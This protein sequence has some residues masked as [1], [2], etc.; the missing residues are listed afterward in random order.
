MVNLSNEYIIALVILIGIVINYIFNKFSKKKLP[1][2]KEKPIIKFEEM[3]NIDSN[4]Y[5]INV[6]FSFDIVNNKKEISKITITN[7]YIKDNN[8]YKVCERDTLKPISP[9]HMNSDNIRIDD[10][11]SKKF[12]Q[13]ICRTPFDVLFDL[14]KNPFLG[15][16]NKDDINNDIVIRTLFNKL[17]RF[18]MP[19]T[20]R[21][22]D[23]ILEKYRNNTISQKSTSNGLIKILNNNLRDCNIRKDGENHFYIHCKNTIDIKMLNCLNNKF[24]YKTNRQTKKSEL[25]K[26]RESYN[27]MIP[28]LIYSLEIIKLDIR[29]TNWYEFYIEL[30]Y[31]YI[32]KLEKCQKFKS[33]MSNHN[34][35]SI[36]TIIK[37]FGGIR[38]NRNY[39]K[40]KI[41]KEGIWKN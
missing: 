5:I 33:H 15:E 40:E 22:C 37:K 13:I 10:I 19:M 11:L 25:L 31:K 16:L 9:Y 36:S 7:K 26:D 35:L 12:E 24:K 4:S 38:L 32:N 18:N 29:D 21:E 3:S 2:D 20:Y 23:Y 39:I 41:I 34:R 1:I 30:I 6:S 17:N 28:I 27:R 8:K 14:S